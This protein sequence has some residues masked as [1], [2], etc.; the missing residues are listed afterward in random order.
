[1]IFGEV[2]NDDFRLNADA[3]RGVS[4]STETLRPDEK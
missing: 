4:E 2:F 3:R 1:M